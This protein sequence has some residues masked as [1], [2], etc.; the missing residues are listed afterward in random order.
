MRYGFVRALDGATFRAEKG[1]VVGLLG[2]NGAGKTTTMRI[3]TTYLV[4]SA[5][6]ATVAGFDVADQPLEVRRRIGYLPES[7]P[8][9]LQMEVRECLEF[10][11]RARGLRGAEL[12]ERV[13]WVVEKCA[14]DTMFSSPVL[15]LSKGYRQRTALAQALIHD[16][17][18]VILDEPT[19]GLDPHQIVEIRQLV[20]ELAKTK[21]IVLSTHILSEANALADR[22]IVMSN[23]KIVGMGTADELRRQAGVR[24]KLRLRLAAAAPDALER[25]RSVPG[26]LD[27]RTDGGVTFDMEEDAPGLADRLGVLARS[28][29]WTVVELSREPGSLEDMFLELTLAGGDPV[30]SETPPA[31]SGPPAAPPAENAA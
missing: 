27:A 17:E 28:A 7:L 1:E 15:Q 22:L 16:P 29:G 21:C 14:L 13:R 30:A 8:L 19:T 26:V 9:Y 6:S 5:G 20:R 18:V 23:G 10:V 4:P 11:G 31:P 3:L 25:L 24:P 12:K 2:S